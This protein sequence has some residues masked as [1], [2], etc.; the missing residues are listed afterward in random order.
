MTDI[1]LTYA[2]GTSLEQMVVFQTASE[3]WSHYLE[4]ETTVNIHVQV[5]DQLG[6]NIIGAALPGIV[7]QQDYGDY[8]Q[9]LTQNIDSKN[10]ED[11]LKGLQD[12][13]E[14]SV[15]AA[16][17]N[18]EFRGN[19][20]I[21]LTN[22][23]AKAVGLETNGSSLD[24]FILMNDLSSQPSYAWDYDVLRAEKLDSLWEQDFKA[25]FSGLR[26]F[27]QV[28]EVQ[29]T[30]DSSS[31]QTLDLL[32]VAL[33]EIGHVL[34]FTSGVDSPIWA[35]TLADAADGQLWDSDAF[36]EKDTIQGQ[37]VTYESE[38]S[39]WW[40]RYLKS[41][42]TVTEEHTVFEA[43]DIETATALD[44][45]RYSKDSTKLGQND[46]SIGNDPYFSIDGGET[47]LAD[48]ASG[49][50]RTLG[51]DGY[52]ASHWQYD[53]Y[54]PE[55]ILDPALS[56]ENRRNLSASDLL[57]LDV[58][59]W[60]IS[61]TEIA[62][63]FSSFKTQAEQALADQLGVDVDWLRT[64]ADTAADL[65]SEDQL[66][67]VAEMIKQSEIYEWGRRASTRTYTRWQEVVDL[68]AQEGRFS[69]ID[70]LPPQP[71]QGS[72][73]GRSGGD[74]AARAQVD[75]LLGRR[76]GRTGGRKRLIPQTRDPLT[77]QTGGEA[78]EPRPPI[79]P[80]T[81]GSGNARPFSRRP[82][83]P[84][85]NPQVPGQ[86]DSFDAPINLGRTATPSLGA[87]D[88][89]GTP[90]LPDVLTAANLPGDPLL[91]GTDVGTQALLPPLA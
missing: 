54:N 19:D 3:I 70:S 23:N 61:D 35:E 8:Y 20:S 29:S 87:G 53:R 9:S 26:S 28:S 32:S 30:G 74:R 17:G 82:T 27:F 41:T 83:Q 7:A 65:L 14:F 49:K 84:I 81:G 58:I 56:P 77:G 51:G 78:G 80:V 6:P 12:S 79:S 15:F 57:A 39:H 71:S 33:H 91:L 72:A 64:N 90:F 69:T 88:R 40:S 63:D 21:Q 48:F 55:G 66:D 18:L 5:T 22:A 67:A 73:A 44:L 24:G 46:L 59:G 16:N 75:P 68:L 43:A 4:D 52:Q 50:D 86:R 47:R 42:T 60:D 10:D 85:G 1:N 89:T 25:F 45:F 38:R 34:G 2:D 62:T 31:E 13:E 11:V 76:P 37:T 36:P